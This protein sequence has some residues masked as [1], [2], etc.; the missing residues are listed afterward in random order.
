[1]KTK[2]LIAFVLLTSSIFAQNCTNF[3]QLYDYTH[4]KIPLSGGAGSHNGAYNYMLASDSYSSHTFG[5]SL[6]Y[7]LESYIVMYKATKDKDYIFKA[8]NESLRMMSWRESNKRFS[9]YFYK[10]GIICWGMAHLA[11]NILIECPELKQVIIP[12]NILEIPN[13]TIT[14][15]ILPSMT[16]SLENI[17]NWLCLKTNEGLQEYISTNWV[18]AITAFENDGDDN[19]LAINMQS[20]FGAAMLYLGKIGTISPNYTYLLPM[21]DYGATIARL[22]KQHISF[23]DKCACDDY[24]N[25]L[26]IETSD[27]S[28]W[29][30]HSGWS[31]VRDNNGCSSSCFPFVHINQIEKSE[32]VQFKEDIS[33]ALVTLNLPKAANDINLYTHNNYPF[34]DEVMVKFRNMFSKKI[35]NGDFNNPNFSNAVDGTQ[36]PIYP[37]GRPDNSFNDQSIAYMPFYKYDNYNASA[38]NVYDIVMNYFLNFYNLGNISNG[39]NIYGLSEIVKAYYDKECYDLT[40][41]NRKLTYNQ[42]FY[43][44]HN[45]DINP[46]SY[47][48]YHAANHESF[49]DPIITANVFS[50]EPNIHSSISADNCVTLKGEVYLKSGSEVVIYNTQGNCYTDGKMSIPPAVN[51]GV[52]NVIPT[53]QVQQQLSPLAEP[54]I[55]KT[56]S[57]KNIITLTPNPASKQFTV[58]SYEPFSQI[59]IYSI[60]GQTMAQVQQLNHTKFDFNVN[61]IPNGVYFV[62]IETQAGREIKK[63]V[64]AKE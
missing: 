29:W 37:V 49:A 54:F 27:N 39:I 41:Y 16:Y 55:D 14:T 8:I 4:S 51:D 43:A 25:D 30:Y 52:S 23:E 56:A 63:V 32:Y 19:A 11:Y 28:Y 53:P 5:E 36:Q 59:N 6:G 47:D 58:S 48:C 42:D 15:N 64:I 46:T 26:L 17:A 60:T 24:D 18:D 31:F 45:L 22:Y 44:K 13:S 35:F 3:K 20:S 38:P 34:S 7:L 61:E 50:V 2:L 40:L 9:I 12:S 1:M 62:S 57:T 10:N 33:H 21:L